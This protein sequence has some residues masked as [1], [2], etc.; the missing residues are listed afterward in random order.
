MNLSFPNHVLKE[1]SNQRTPDIIEDLETLSK[2]F[3][4]KK[5]KTDE[6]FKFITDEET[7]DTKNFAVI[8]LFGQDTFSIFTKV[9]EHETDSK[10]KSTIYNHTN[11]LYQKNNNILMTSIPTTQ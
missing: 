4:A 1:L 2:H 8:N 5:F 3:N 11:H 9:K 7:F 10:R 6:A